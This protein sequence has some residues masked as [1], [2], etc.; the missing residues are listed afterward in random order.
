MKKIL[1]SLSIISFLT[2]TTLPTNACD[3]FHDDNSSNKTKPI[4]NYYQSFNGTYSDYNDYS[5]NIKIGSWKKYGNTWSEVSSKYSTITFD[6][7]SMIEVNTPTYNNEWNGLKPN[8]LNEPD[9][10]IKTA[11]IYTST[12]ESFWKVDFKYY[13]GE[14]HSVL[15]AYINIWYNESNGNIYLKWHLYENGYWLQEGPYFKLILN[16]FYFSNN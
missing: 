9:L 2:I 4:Y 8:K 1:S 11:D 6:D 13:Y 10:I 14:V 5:E 12:K 3:F 15:D 16:S 7:S